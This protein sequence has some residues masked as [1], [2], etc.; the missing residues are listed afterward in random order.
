M[1]YLSINPYSGEQ[2]FSAET[3][4][5]EQIKSMLAKS[6]EAFLC[7]KASLYRQR[8]ELLFKVADLL[9]ERADE[10]AAMIT[11]E[12][13]KL[14]HEAVAEVFKCAA[15]CRYYA[16]NAEIFLS[17]KLI[18]ACGSRTIVSIQPLGAVLA[19]MPWNF[20]FWQVI[21]CASA[22][23]M[24][25]NCVV[26][27]HASNV[28]I[29][30]GALEK[31]FLDAGAIEG[32]FINLYISSSQVAEVIADPVI[33]AV[34]LT[35]SEAAGRSVASLAGQA[36]KPSLLE[37]GGS[38][39]F[40]VLGD[41]DI[42]FAVE[43]ALSSRYMNAGQSCIAAKRFVVVDSV[44]DKFVEL[45]KQKV[46]LL[47]VGDPALESTTLAPMARKDLCEELHQQ[48]QDAVGCGATVVIGCEY[49]GDSCIYPASII[50][51]VTEQMR[52]YNEEVFGPVATIIRVKDEAE[53]VAVANGSR[54]GLGGSVWTSDSDK[55]E[56]IARSLE[57]GNAFVNSIVKSDPKAPFGGI[58]ESGYGRE[59]SEYGIKEFV[60]I[61]TLSVSYH[62]GS[63]T[64]EE[65][66]SKLY[67]AVEQR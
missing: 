45:F 10:Y 63:D 46:Q 54:F 16:E 23:I 65:K 12:M 14:R 25:G 5:S 28:G 50:D 1:S 8:A 44:A 15:G 2:V 66:D 43:N 56:S 27:K 29:C 13:G 7:W 62:S 51:N 17:D 37:L 61:K 58:K 47:T 19:V 53:A 42:E 57:C 39:P 59:L 9:E 4:S 32:L 21:R 40:I 55:G 41:A 38:D 35:G 20:P 67:R 26:L 48:V 34:A 30:A 33:A 6:A 60:N 36:I 64:E 24:A 49:Y 3:L 31:L 52:V 11:S 18:D 22:A